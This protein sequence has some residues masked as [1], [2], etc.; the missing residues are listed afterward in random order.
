MDLPWQKCELA[1]LFPFSSLFPSFIFVPSFLFSIH[2]KHLF[3]SIHSSRSTLHLE[4]RISVELGINCQIKAGQKNPV[5]GKG[6]QEE[7]KE[8]KTPSLP[9]FGIPHNKIHQSNNRYVKDLRQTHAGSI[10]A[11]SA[12]V[13][14]AQLILWTTF[15]WYPRP[16]WLLPF[17][18]P[19]LPQCS[20]SSKWRVPMESSNLGSLCA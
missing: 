13:S 14:P 1:C 10:T 11:A 6:S 15:S 12:S 16:L 7:A 17:L 20:L 4:P 8:S 3:P 18:L 19:P 2:S 5:G 9:L